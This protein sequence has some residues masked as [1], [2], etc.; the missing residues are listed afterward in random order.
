MATAN[1]S[2]TIDERSESVVLLD[3][4]WS[5]Y[6]RLVRDLER[7][8]KRLTYDKGA[9]EIMSPSP[10]HEHAKEWLGKMVTILAEEFEVDFIF[11]GSTTLK[12]RKLKK[13]LEPNQC[14]WIANYE[15]I[16]DRN[17]INLAKDPPPDL[18]VEI[19][20]TSSSLNRMKIYAKLGVPEVWRYD[21]SRLFVYSLDAA[22]A[23]TPVSRSVAFPDFPVALIEK[24]IE[25]PSGESDL[26]SIRR[27]RLLARE[28]VVK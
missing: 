3:I 15:R 1:I 21:G 18:V 23:Y 7:Q 4:Q 12:V 17:T 26:Q 25:R 14:Y 8:S 20:I 6:C 2:P 28:H 16:A 27:F 11:G 13:G 10:A 9:L 24:N 5:T 22:R 19:D